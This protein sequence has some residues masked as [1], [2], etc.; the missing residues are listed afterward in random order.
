MPEVDL[1]TSTCPS[2]RPTPG[3]DARQRRQRRR[4]RTAAG[5]A[6]GGTGNAK[7]PTVDTGD[8]S[9]VNRADSTCAH[10]CGRARDKVTR[11]RRARPRTPTARPTRPTRPSRCR[12]P[13]P[14][15]IGVPNFFIDKFRIPPFLLPIYQAAGIQ[16]GVR[17]EILAAINE[18]ETDYGRN[19]NVSSAGAARLDA[20]PALDL[21][22]CTASTPTATSVADPYNPVDAIFA[23]A[24]Y[25]TRRRRR[26]GHPPGGLRL[27]PR[28]LVRRLR[29]P[30]RP[31]HRRPAVE[32]RRLAHGPHAGPLPD[33]GQGHLRRRDP[34]ARPQ[35]SARATRRWSSSPSGRRGIR[36]FSRERAPVVAVNDGRSSASATTERARQLRDAAGRLRQHVHVRAPG[37]GRPPLPVAEAA[38]VRPERGRGAARAADARRPAGR[39]RVATRRARPRRAPKRKLAE[40]AAPDVKKT[41]A[42]AADKQRLFANPARPN[43]SAAGGAQQEFERTGEIDGEETFAG[44]FRRVFGLGRKDIQLKRLRVGSRVVAGHDPRPPRRARRPPRPVPALR[45]PPGRPGRAAD[46]PE[47]DPR[48]LEAARVDGDLPRRRQEPVLRPRRR[49]PVD[50]PDPADE[51]GGARPARPRQPA[52]RHLRLRPARHPDRADR[53]PRPGH[54]RV[55]RRLRPAAD[56]HLAASC[57]HGFYTT[58]GQRVAPLVRQRGRHRGGQ[59]HHD[60]AGDPGRGLDHRDDDPAPAD[61]AGHDAARPDHLADEVRGRRQHVRDGRPRRPHPRRLPAALRH[62]LEDGQAGQRDPQAQ[63][64]D[65]ADRPPRRDRQP[66]GAAASRRSTRTPAS[67]AHKGE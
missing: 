44:Y 54:A 52:D 37:Q 24:R 7:P 1:P 57:G 18:I 41:E 13:A 50:R 55:P 64:V 27:Q 48:R 59:R 47:A 17:W 38:G 14:A 3:D 60:L 22:R 62:Q 35:A 34:D 33:P 46:R 23:A 25:L 32:P 11:S 5:N 15:R 4:R 65:Q 61:P 67:D 10:A 2:R 9:A 26:P 51:Q 63:A 28:R 6:G 16:Y 56:G 8:E 12:P 20:V 19:L 45:D 39:G 29:A 21:A 66:D 31:G 53:P 58:L 49:Q 36:I 40:K 30:A 42:P 43:A